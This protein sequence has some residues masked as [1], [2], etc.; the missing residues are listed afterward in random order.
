MILRRATKSVSLIPENNTKKMCFYKFVATLLLSLTHRTA[1]I[2]QTNR[3][4]Q[5]KNILHRKITYHKQRN[6]IYHKTVIIRSIIAVFL[7]LYFI[8]IYFYYPFI[9]RIFVPL[10]YHKEKSGLFVPH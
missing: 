9:Y 10:M 3:L 1:K 4:Y 8:V 2:L 6:N 5:I 7:S